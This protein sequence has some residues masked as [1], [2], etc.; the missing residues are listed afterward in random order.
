LTIK[1]LMTGL[2]FTPDIVGG[3]DLCPYSDPIK[4][5]EQ[6]GAGLGIIYSLNDDISGLKV[7]FT[8]GDISGSKELKV[9]LAEPEHPGKHL[10]KWEGYDTWMS[11]ELV[12]AI[13]GY[14]GELSPPSKGPEHVVKEGDYTVDIFMKRDGDASQTQSFKIN[15]TVGYKYTQ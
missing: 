12:D 13:Y 2:T 4:L 1:P 10:I 9:K 7:A 3:D 11:P 15:F 14:P 6:T 8:G 5:D